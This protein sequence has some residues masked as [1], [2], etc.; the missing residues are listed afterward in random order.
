MIY[1]AHT[2]HAMRL[3][4]E[5]HHGQVDK[6]GLPYIYHP[7]H[8]A[9][10]MPDEIT[11]I[12]ALLHDTVE[13]TNLTIDDL[14]AEGFPAEAI[15]AVRRLTHE[16]SVPYLD[17][18]RALRDN[19]I[20]V[21]VKLADLVHNSDLTRMSTITDKDLERREKYQKAINILKTT[22][23]VA[24]LI[25]NGNKFMI[26]QRPA[27]KARGLLW[28]FVGG[29]VEPGES[30]KHALIRECQEELAVT[31]AVDHVFMDVTHFYPDLTIH[32]TLFNAKI[33]GGTPQKLEHHDI[34]WITP[35]EIDAYEFCP[36]D[37]NILKE[38]KYRS[39][40]YSAVACPFCKK[41]IP[42]AY[43]FCSQCGNPI[44]SS[45][46]VPVSSDLFD[47][48]NTLSF[49]LDCGADNFF[50]NRYCGNCGKKL[51]FNFSG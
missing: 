50:V 21:T 4:Y 24:A 31:I 11:T 2:K 36:A 17:Y 47:W 49:C 42:A 22:E 13:D 48:E 29:K 27:H 35:E 15:E 23:V 12:A 26:C 19:P 33:A 7:L 39:N 41:I 10:Q 25:W 20:A 46:I 18:I 14:R 44:D 30:K 32:L 9:E 37:V 1:T 43:H 8:L 28:E 16:D 5:A 45:N 6:D 34:Q 38:I 51:H 40:K 3:A